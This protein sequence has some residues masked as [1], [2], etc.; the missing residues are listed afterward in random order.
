MK[1][2]RTA[3]L[4]AALALCM[5]LVLTACG[6]G[7]ATTSYVATDSGSSGAY[8]TA[9]SSAV[10]QGETSKTTD[11]ETGTEV[12]EDTANTASDRKLIYTT[13][14]S[15]ETL[16]YETFMSK[17]KALVTEN[18]AYIETSSENGI[19][20][21][22]DGLRYATL[23]VRVPSDHRLVFESGVN[24]LGNVTSTQQ[25][26][27]DIT[28]QYVDNESRID[29][30]KTEESRLIELLKT[31]KKVED[32]ITIE[33]RLSDVRYELES[34]ESTKRTYDNSVD[35]STVTISVNEVKRESS[36]VPKNFWERL[37]EA[38]TEGCY[39]FS[40]GFQGFV[41]WLAGNIFQLLV[42]AAIIAAVVLFLR[43]LG[44][45]SREERRRRRDE[46][47]AA[48][49]RGSGTQQR[50]GQMNGTQPG[51]GM[52]QMNGMP[53]N[54]GTQQ[55]NGMP[56]NSGVQ[57][58]APADQQAGVPAGQDQQKPEQK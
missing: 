6:S 27:Q 26:V 39:R 52:Q 3:L 37:S 9:S 16:E 22:S 18:G 29:A 13:Q 36:S 24:A 14:I 10:V 8:D 25:S 53:Q 57:P 41:V 54:G 48:R 21:D 43:R 58:A 1:T 35:Y 46:K 23:T 12:K 33:N 51:G 19:S 44:S 4:T 34:Y 38:F 2:R 40:E 7:S 5:A 55:M 28:L 32:I 45:G 15:I 56:Q 11:S 49:T 30:L 47:K 50:P 20:Y 42:W 31:A 17:L